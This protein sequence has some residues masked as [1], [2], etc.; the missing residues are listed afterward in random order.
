MYAED[1]AGVDYHCFTGR[2]N[3][4]WNNACGDVAGLYDGRVFEDKAGYDPQP[5]E[6]AVLFRVGDK[7]VL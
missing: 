3:Y 6:G 7:L 4:I 2:R 5:P 1:V